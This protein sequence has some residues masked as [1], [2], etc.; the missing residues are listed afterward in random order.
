[1]V[2][3]IPDIAFRDSDDFKGIATRNP[4][5]KELIASVYMNARFDI[6]FY[7]QVQVFEGPHGA[8][9]GMYSFFPSPQTK[10]PFPPFSLLP[11]LKPQPSFS[12]ER[13]ISCDFKKCNKTSGPAKFII[14]GG[15]QPPSDAAS[16][17]DFD[18]WY[19]DEHLPLL[20]RAPGFIR[21]RRYEVVT[22]YKL[23][24]LQH[25]DAMPEVPQYLA[26]HEFGGEAL[27]WK[28]IKESLNSEWAEKIIASV[29]NTE[30]GWYQVK[31]VY[32]ESEWGNVGK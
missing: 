9:T 24:Q 27:P 32:P 22:A 28:E 31:R 23:D 16:T 6:R 15:L 8:E 10:S 3:E 1:V 17:A 12:R 26:L 14:S 25:A 13:N 11:P 2:Y 29:Q 21:S 4:P 7:K 5:S 20:S 18:K 30:I 19:R